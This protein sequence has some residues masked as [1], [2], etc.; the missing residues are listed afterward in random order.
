M[1]IERL[2][3]ADVPVFEQAMALYQI[4]F[5]HH[6]QRKRAS[7]REIMFHESYHFG[8]IWEEECFVG[9]MLYWET[10]SYLYVEHFCTLP[11]LRGQ[12]LGQKALR[13]LAEQGKTIIL[14]IDPPV[15]DISKRRKG[16]YERVG[17]RA[18]PYAHV[19]PPYHEE[20]GGHD[21]VVMSLPGQLSQ[22]EYDGFARYLAD[23]VMS[24]V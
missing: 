24:F 9:L 7:Q 3:L 10:D 18:N 2:R 8:V 15:D 11:G 14:E 20:Y 17:F 23:T 21:L 6:E 13:L 22:A 19:H 5:P 1:K 12:G 4:S 16:F